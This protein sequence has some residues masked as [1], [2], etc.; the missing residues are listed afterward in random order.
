VAAYDRRVIVARMAAGRRQKAE[1]EPR[2]R[3]QG[4]R[5][6]H[7]YRRTRSG[8]VEVDADAAAEVR[9]AFELVR[10]GCT[11]RDAAAALG[12]HTTML[13]RVLKRPQYKAAGDWRIVDPRVWNAAQVALASR[14]KLSA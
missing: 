12:W 11:V 13:A 6:P 10:D 9:R 3:A 5:L 1:R 14:R 4:G 7:G 2:S 8:G